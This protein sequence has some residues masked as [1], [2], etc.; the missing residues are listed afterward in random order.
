MLA[1][2]RRMKMDDHVPAHWGS[3]P[4]DSRDQRSASQRSRPITDHPPQQDE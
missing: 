2:T 1:L 3:A 4:P